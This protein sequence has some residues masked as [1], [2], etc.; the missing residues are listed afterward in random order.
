MN[1]PQNT[2]IKSKRYHSILENFRGKW[3]T[4]SPLLTNFDG[5]FVKAIIELPFTGEVATNGWLP[6]ILVN[7]EQWWKPGMEATNSWR[8]RQNLLCEWMKR[9]HL[10][11]VFS[12][13]IKCLAT[14]PRYATERPNELTRKFSHS[15]SPWIALTE[16]MLGKSSSGKAVLYSS[17]FTYHFDTC[18]K[19]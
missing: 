16:K 6:N 11:P 10:S 15:N 8:N 13:L 3:P 2:K 9:Q 4:V 17:T 7:M 19:D 1:H 18:Y 14:K 12:P 5:K